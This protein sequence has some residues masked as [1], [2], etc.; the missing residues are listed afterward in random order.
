MWRQASTPRSWPL[1][2]PASQ[3]WPP[4]PASARERCLLCALRGPDCFIVSGLSR[5]PAARVVAELANFFRDFFDLVVNFAKVRPSSLPVLWR[6]ASTARPWPLRP[7]TPHARMTRGALPDA[8]TL[9][10]PTFRQRMRASVY[11]GPRR[12]PRPPK[13]NDPAAGRVAYVDGSK[14]DSGQTGPAFRK[15]REL[16]LGN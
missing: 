10:F 3:S 2:P 7:T 16:I 9:S 5:P 1:R 14:S 13:K 15:G 6:P 4:K 12:T 11:E 8:R